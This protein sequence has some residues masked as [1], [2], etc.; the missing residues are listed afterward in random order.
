MYDLSIGTIFNDLEVERLLTQARPVFDVYVVSFHMNILGL[1]TKIF[2]P[3]G[4]EVIPQNC[5]S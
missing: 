3:C 4:M 1:V 2:Q 5:H